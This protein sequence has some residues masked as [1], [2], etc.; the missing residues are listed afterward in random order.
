MTR[1]LH[2]ALACVL[3][4]SVAACTHTDLAR[5]APG[6][7]DVT[8]RP[9]TEGER[10]PGDPGEQIVTFAYGGFA[11]AGV[12]SG[13][14]STHGTYALGPEISVGYG[15]RDT[16]HREDDWFVLPERGA[17]LDVGLTALAYE[18]N[19]IGPAYAQAGVRWGE[20]GKVAAGWAWDVD[21]RTHGPQLT[22]TFVALYA[23]MT[24]QLDTSTAV[25]FGL[26]IKG[27][28]GWVWSR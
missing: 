21:D 28:H 23:R 10:A 7:V 12:G 1:A 8:T 14:G 24:H 26:A 11:G 9:T 3:G 17:V 4:A 5:N 22:L 20:L 27:E 15:T 13:A 6:V 18:G 19:G 2:G 16:S 25:T